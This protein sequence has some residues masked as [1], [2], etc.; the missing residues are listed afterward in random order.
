MGAKGWLEGGG[1][2]ARAQVR[3]VKGAKG[4]GGGNR[5]VKTAQLADGGAFCARR[6]GRAGNGTRREVLQYGVERA[7]CGASEKKVVFVRE[8]G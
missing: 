5:K 3:R 4:K 7:V 8:G 6:V 2:T 1:E